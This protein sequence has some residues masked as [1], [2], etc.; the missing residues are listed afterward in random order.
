MK[1]DYGRET[2]RYVVGKWIK[3]RNYYKI[4]VGNSEGKG[5]LEV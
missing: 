5:P 1:Y 4:L 2:E 3:M